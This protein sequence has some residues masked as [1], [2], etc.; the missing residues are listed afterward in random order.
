MGFQQYKHTYIYTLIFQPFKKGV[1]GSNYK[2]DV[3]CTLMAKNSTHL[4]T[5]S[6]HGS[7]AG[8][9][10]DWVLCSRSDKD[11]G[12]TPIATCAPGVSSGKEFTPK[13]IQVASRTDSPV[14]WKEGWQLAGVAHNM[15][16]YF[17]VRR[18]SGSP[19]C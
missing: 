9:K 8:P 11:T 1:Q 10:L 12:K 19:V 7:G 6:L 16:S 2:K 17:S 18:E 14:L 15:T 5:H 3:L 4:S 13:R